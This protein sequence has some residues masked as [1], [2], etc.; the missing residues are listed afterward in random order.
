MEGK[1]A[2]HR[3]GRRKSDDLSPLIELQQ[4]IVTRNAGSLN[5][6]LEETLRIA[7][8]DGAMAES[9]NGKGWI[10]R[11]GAG[12]LAGYAGENNQPA[13]GVAI[14]GPVKIARG[15][16]Q[17]IAAIAF[18]RFVLTV[19]ADREDAFP[20]RDEQILQLLAG[21]AMN[22]VMETDTA[23]KITSLTAAVEREAQF[24]SLL[25]DIAVAANE[26]QSVEEAIRRSL[27]RISDVTG[28][29][30]GHLYLTSERGDRLIS[31]KVW[32]T[33]DPTRFNALRRLTDVLEW[34]KGVGLPGQVLAEA[35]PA[36]V[37][38]IR[39]DPS[40]VRTA[41]ATSLGVHSSFA[42][43]LLI[44]SEVV[45]VLE[46]FSGEVLQ[47]DE[48]LLEIAGQIGVQLG[49]VIE[50]KRSSI[51]LA[52]SEQHYRLLFER[53]LAGVFR[54][55]MDGKIIDCNE[56]LA[57]IVGYDSRSELRD[58]S[59]FDLYPESPER[60][61]FFARLKTGRAVTNAEMLLER[62]DGAHVW[63]LV[64]ASVTDFGESQVIEGS[65]LD[66][67]AKKEED[68]R[69]EY[70][71]QHDALTKLHNRAFFR[72]QLEKSLALAQRYEHPL[73]L[74]FMDLDG[75]KPINDTLGHAAGDWL[76]Q[77]TA[78]RLVQSVR[79]S[80]LVARLGGDEFVVL[81]TTLTNARDAETVAQKLLS[82][83]SSPFAYNGH[84]LVVSASIGIGL[85]PD[86]A[87]DSEM[88]IAAAD[89][90]MYAAKKS[91]G[92]TY[93]FLNWTPSKY[94]IRE[95]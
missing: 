25:Q 3:R 44:G 61:D 5:L 8:A 31:T 14:D 64:N 34:R 45:A 74:L 2:P 87:A 22:V 42:F 29:P 89:E 49:R 23:P 95:P 70:Q 93:R 60:E 26:A 57:R 46:F 90:A 50:R 16:G 10:F 54:L 53:N 85:Y 71:A 84:D 37:V 63:T 43:P 76:L 12:S 52:A 21:F 1:A 32:H 11:G 24:I 79:S 55:A 27:S 94:N 59:M 80:D 13:L 92:H 48:R 56:A 6:V 77:E 15:G 35:K 72:S 65:L 51:S 62:R 78:T 81:L 30:V 88:L 86:D 33:T 41:V 40:I 36:W 39:K 73:G 83:L 69:V 28:W 82:R 58:L 67:T 75:F 4:K 91:G 68:L 38:D 20:P 17:S 7:E 19:V 18:P 66:V 9:L 47:P